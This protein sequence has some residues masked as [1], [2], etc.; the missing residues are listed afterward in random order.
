MGVVHCGRGRRGFGEPEIQNFNHAARGDLY[1]GGL[2]IPMD[3]SFLV[4]SLKRCSDLTG[5]GERFLQR[6]RSHGSDSV[7]Q[8]H[9]EVVRADV[10]ELADVGVIQ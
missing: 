2:E 8:F 10:V 4:R 1:I 9:D 6:H 3:D 5:D 7:D